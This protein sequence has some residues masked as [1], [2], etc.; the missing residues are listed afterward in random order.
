VRGSGLGGSAY[1][2]FWV[3]FVMKKMAKEAMNDFLLECNKRGK[4]LSSA[5]RK[6]SWNVEIY[7]EIENVLKSVFQNYIFH[8]IL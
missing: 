2:V 7:F 1:P 4:P 6:S 5:N 8:S 3:W